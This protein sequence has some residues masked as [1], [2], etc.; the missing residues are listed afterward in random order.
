MK[1]LRLHVSVVVLC[2]FWYMGY[3]GNFFAMLCLVGMSMNLCAMWCNG[4]KM[5]VRLKKNGWLDENDL[6]CSDIP[7]S[8][9]SR[10]RWMCDIIHLGPIGILSAGDIVLII[11]LF[12]IITN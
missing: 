7:L 12:L 5:P 10:V 4:R 11:A 8:D 6:S 9:R 3:F 1:F 2:I